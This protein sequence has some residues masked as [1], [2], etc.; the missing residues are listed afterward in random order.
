MRKILYSILICF[1][2]GLSAQTTTDISYEKARLAPAMNWECPEI[3]KYKELLLSLKDEDCKIYASNVMEHF[4]PGED[5]TL[6]GRLFLVTQAVLTTDNPV[7]NVHNLNICLAE[8]LRKHG[9]H[10]EMRYVSDDDKSLQTIASMNVS[11]HAT[12]GLQNKVFVFPS[13]TLKVIEGNKLLVSFVT[14]HYKYVDYTENGK[15]E[16]FSYV[17]K[18]AEVYPFEKKGS[19]KKSF[20]KAYVGT[21]QAFWNTISELKNYLNTNFTRDTKMLSQ[22]HYQYS[23]DSLKTKYGEPEMVINGL[24]KNLD[25]NNEVYIFEKAGKVVFMGKTINFEDIMS[26]EIVDDPKFIPGK[27]VTTGMGIAFFG[28]ALGGTESSRTPDKTIH[29]YVVDVKI[30]NLST[31]FIRIAVGNN[32][33]KATEI[34]SV[35][36]YILRHQQEGKSEV[37]KQKTATRRK[38]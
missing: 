8:W 12:F 24:S 31:P 35:F 27:S 15:K 26:C 28:L 13:L 22:L 11:S 21:Y 38:M 25:I 18:V 37:Q 5:P 29:N 3:K 7:F 34:A 4:K 9:W 14:D 36:E 2:L 16:S 23:K 10:K 32:D 19:Y 6:Q 30:D 20:A 17:A 33:K 1:S